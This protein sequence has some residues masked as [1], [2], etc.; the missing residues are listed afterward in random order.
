MRIL[1]IWI[2]VLLTA[3]GG[4]AT[5]SQDANY[6]ERLRINSPFVEPDI[7]TRGQAIA[8]YS[9]LGDYSELIDE[10]KY[11]ND[12]GTLWQWLSRF[13]LWIETA[14]EDCY[15]VI[16]LSI[17]LELHA[18]TIMLHHMMEQEL[19]LSEDDA[20]NRAMDMYFA[21]KEP[22]GID[23]TIPKEEMEIN[24]A[25]MEMIPCKGEDAVAFHQA[26][27]EYLQIVRQ[28]EEI[29]DKDSLQSWSTAYHSWRDEGWSAFF[30]APCGEMIPQIVFF[31]SLAYGV[32]LGQ[33][34]HAGEFFL[35]TF[36]VLEEVLEYAHAAEI[37]FLESL[38]GEDSR[39]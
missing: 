13:A 23:R 2:C 7:C 5:F 24:R 26:S 22:L 29:S 36:D 14:G 21:D 38:E 35:N 1:M 27:I 30:V 25:R 8:F 32:A 12:G 3:V 39:Q 6:R 31:D 16:N 18:R 17:S 34:T 10:I 9:T 4:T 15:G 28:A 19:Q 33:L 37:K 11:V 20:F